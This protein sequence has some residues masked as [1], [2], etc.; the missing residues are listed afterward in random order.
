MN[1]QNIDF[2]E[3]FGKCIIPKLSPNITLSKWLLFLT[4]DHNVELLFDWQNLF[5][6]NL[7]KSQSNHPRIDWYA[8][9]IDWVWIG[10]ATLLRSCWD[11]AFETGLET[12]A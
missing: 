12:Y 11:I 5:L 4:W 9:L 8:L 7:I 2:I 6:Q 3:K 1:T 10:Q